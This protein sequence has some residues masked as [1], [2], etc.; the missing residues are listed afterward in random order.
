MPKRKCKNCGES[1]DRETMFIHGVSAYCSKESMIKWAIANQAKGRK[2]I[3][4]SDRKIHAKRKRAFYDTDIKTRKAAAKH[5]CHAY[6][7]ER[8]RGNPCI[9][10]GRP[11]GKNFDAGHFLES[12]NNPQIRYDEDNIHAQSVYCNQYQG[13]NSSDYRARLVIK[14]GADNVDRL[15]CMRGGVVKRSC[16]DYRAIESYYKAKLKEL[17]TKQC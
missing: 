14:I 1:K 5:A 8:D 13:G 3:E 11:L 7:R 17:T 10:C 2:K 9:C 6:I 16:D 4:L 15:E 12:G